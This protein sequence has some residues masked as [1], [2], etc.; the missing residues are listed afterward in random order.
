MTVRIK[1]L[2]AQL[3]VV[4]AA[5]AGPASTAHASLK[6]CNRTSSSVRYE[7][8]IYDSSCDASNPWRQRGWWTIAANAC[9]TVSN[10]NMFGLTFYFYAEST[11]GS[12][13]WRN[14]QYTWEVWPSPVDECMGYDFCETASGALCPGHRSLGHMRI[15]T[16]SG[17]RDF[18][19]N[20]DPG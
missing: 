8:A 16:P 3:T 2:A 13:V 7:H 1:L 20:L 12:L 9:A 10:R 17:Q 19:L 18:T 5:L 11:N 15:V 6:I 14:S 4:I